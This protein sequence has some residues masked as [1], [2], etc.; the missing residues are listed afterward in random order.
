MLRIILTQ[1]D[2]YNFTSNFKIIYCY[3]VVIGCTYGLF[4]QMETNINPA[5]EFCEK[6]LNKIKKT[7]CV[8]TGNN[9]NYLKYNG[10][11]LNN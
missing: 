6:F 2:L 8:K 9:I 1:Y 5:N 4:A 7:W 11:A 3:K 10:Q